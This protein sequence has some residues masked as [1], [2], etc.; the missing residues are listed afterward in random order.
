MIDEPIISSEELKDRI[1]NV[2]GFQVMI[3]FHLADLYGMETKRVN[4]QVKRNGKRFPEKFMFQ[5][6]A[7]EWENLKSQ[8]ATSSWGG[9]RKLPYVF[10]EYGVAML[11]AVLN[12]DVAV[13]IS[14]QIMEAFIKLRHLIIE[15]SLLNQRLT[16]IESKQ[17]ETDQKFKQIFEALQNKD[18]V[19]R[20]GVF[21]DGQVFDAYEFASKLI[22]S[23]KSSIVLIDNYLDESSLSHLLKKQTGVDV[24]VLSKTINR[25]FSL[26]LIKVNEQY[27]GF[28][29]KYFSQSHDRFLII[30]NRE[31]YHLGA[32]LK[33]LGKKWFAFSKLEKPSVEAILKAISNL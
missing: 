29:V 30:D 8:F 10:T 25:Q 11:S 6:T 14:I 13:S 31:I 16:Q 28:H 15:S 19:P 20:Q 33:D 17:L 7:D 2:R 23:A 5:L 4:E 22:R 1:F 24:L 9:K 21:F 26:D 27:G 3:D 12:S 32:S 18:S